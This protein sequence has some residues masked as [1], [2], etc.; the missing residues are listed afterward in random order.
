MEI[1]PMTP[2][3]VMLVY[4]VARRTLIAGFAITVALVAVA[5]VLAVVKD[6]PI[7]ESTLPLSDLPSAVR[8]GDPSA[9]AELAIFAIVLTPILTTLGVI[10]AFLTIGDRRYAGISVLVL[11]VLSGSMVVALLR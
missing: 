5:L 11:L 8:D 2:G 1:T 3:P 10:G 6:Q 4:R 9:V 7:A